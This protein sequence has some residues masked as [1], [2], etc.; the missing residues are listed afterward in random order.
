MKISK[1]LVMY[2]RTGCHL[3]EQAAGLLDRVG[4]SWR[5]VDVDDDVELEETYGLR[6]PVLKRRDSGR[7]LDYPFDEAAIRKFAGDPP[8]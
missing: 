5:P 8:T 7:E 6:V 1:P 3:C 4:I 2:T